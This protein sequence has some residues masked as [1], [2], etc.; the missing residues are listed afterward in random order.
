[1][2]LAFLKVLM[3]IRQVHQKTFLEKGFQFQ[4]DICN[5]CHDVLMMPV[6]LSGI[7]VLNI[8]GVDYRC[9]FNGT[10]KSKAMSL[11][12]NKI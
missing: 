2:E 4:P 9:I 8:H 11:S 1:M 7:A 6:N 3:L 12:N 5:G 10:D